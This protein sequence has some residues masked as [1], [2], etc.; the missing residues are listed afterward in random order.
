MKAK[1]RGLNRLYADS[2]ISFNEYRREAERLL[3]N[4][5]WQKRIQYENML[6]M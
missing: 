6:Y 3:R 4:L 5:D 2:R 1:I